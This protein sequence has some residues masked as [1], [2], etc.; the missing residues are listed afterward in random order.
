MNAAVLE[1]GDGEN[2]LLLHF[3]PGSIGYL[4]QVLREGG[5]ILPAIRIKEIAEQLEIHGDI[6]HLQ[7]VV[8]ETAEEFEDVCAQLASALGMDRFHHGETPTSESE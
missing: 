3:N 1:F 8:R 6:T 7:F 5:G 2:T 4:L